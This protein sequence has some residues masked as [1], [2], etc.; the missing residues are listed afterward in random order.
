MCCCWLQAYLQKACNRSCMHWYTRHKL[1]GLLVLYACLIIYMLLYQSADNFQTDKELIDSSP[2]Y[3]CCTRK[4]FKSPFYTVKLG[5]IRCCWTDGAWYLLMKM[6]K[7]FTKR[8]WYI[9]IEKFP[10]FTPFVNLLKT[11]LSV[12]RFYITHRTVEGCNVRNPWS[13]F[14]I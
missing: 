2:L 11:M 6:S 14:P 1:Q 5:R 10:N 13:E 3:L 4:S 9:R 8:L 12:R 7:I